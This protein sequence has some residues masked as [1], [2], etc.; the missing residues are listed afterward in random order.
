[1]T[2]R[3]IDAW[4]GFNVTMTSFM[5]TNITD[6][7]MVHHHHLLHSS[8]QFSLFDLAGIYTDCVL[9]QKAAFLTALS[10]NNTSCEVA[11]LLL[12]SIPV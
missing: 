2:P 1:M 3:R 8:G 12:F 5:R 7:M 4:L 6:L 10:D 11:G 9:R